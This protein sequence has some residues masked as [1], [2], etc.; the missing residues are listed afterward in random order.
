[1][2]LAVCDLAGAKT[3]HISEYRTGFELVGATVVEVER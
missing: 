2:N 3:G 1:M